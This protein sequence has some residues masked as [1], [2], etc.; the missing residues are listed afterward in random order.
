MWKPI[1]IL[2]VLALAVGCGEK[3][4]APDSPES[5]DPAKIADAPEPNQ[6]VMEPA[7]AS[8]PAEALLATSCVSCHELTKVTEAKKS[9]DD[10]AA[11]L[12]ACA[13]G[14]FDEEQTAS[15]LDHLEKTYGAE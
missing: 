12:E 5:P 2:V 4:E 11:Q 10:W 3:S 6:P 13:Q 9:R 8:H 1:L 15:L 14:V 7:G